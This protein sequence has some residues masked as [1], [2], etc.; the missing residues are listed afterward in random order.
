MEGPGAQL[1]ALCG[2]VWPVQAHVLQFGGLGLHQDEEHAVGK[3]LPAPDVPAGTA[4]QLRRIKHGIEE[5][6]NP[7]LLHACCGQR[8]HLR[9]QFGPVHF[10][11]IQ[12]FQSCY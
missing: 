6:E 2:A 10:L 7:A 11:F 9:D 12:M 1:M 8:R 3:P 5:G 4:R